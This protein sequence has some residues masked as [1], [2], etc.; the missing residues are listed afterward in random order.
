MR[1]ICPFMQ[2]K[3]SLIATSNIPDRRLI[4]IDDGKIIL[5]FR[6]LT[7]PEFTNWTKEV[8]KFSQQS[9]SQLLMDQGD[10]VFTLPRTSSLQS[11]KAETLDLNDVLHGDV[12]ELYERV[13][14]D[15]LNIK[16][17]VEGLKEKGE[18]ACY[19]HQPL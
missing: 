14:T 12:T 8:T 10:Q 18:G 5:H 19:V 9:E 13:K 6:A 17:F 4:D 16:K 1:V 11:S 2:L 7:L 15:W 3:L